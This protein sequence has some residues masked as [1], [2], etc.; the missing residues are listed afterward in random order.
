MKSHRELE[1]EANEDTEKKIREAE[2]VY[3][4]FTAAYLYF[5]VLIGIISACIMV[6]NQSTGQ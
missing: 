2:E 6:F 3:D 1:K 4:Y 5:L